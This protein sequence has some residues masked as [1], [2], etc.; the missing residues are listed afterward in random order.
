V[1]SSSEGT[2]ISPS[3]DSVSI[4]T[5]LDFEDFDSLGFFT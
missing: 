4:S 5:S 3:D 1:Q 2:K